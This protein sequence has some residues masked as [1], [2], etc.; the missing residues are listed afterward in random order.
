MVR[1]GDGLGWAGMGDEG[2][3]GMLDVCWI[4]LGM[5][6]WWMV[7]GMVDWGYGDG[8]GL[9]PGWWLPLMV[10]VMDG[11]GWDGMVDGMGWVLL[12]V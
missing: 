8:W 5:V 12:G 2:G 6:N 3:F 10:S 4:E 9:T 7:D 1:A 11:M